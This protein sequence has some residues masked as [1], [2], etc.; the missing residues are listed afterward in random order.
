MMPYFYTTASVAGNTC[1][2][3]SVVGTISSE[4]FCT[5]IPLFSTTL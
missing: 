2:S 3:S 5:T 4:V 1:L